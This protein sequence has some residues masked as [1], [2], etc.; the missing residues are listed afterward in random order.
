MRRASNGL[1]MLLAGAAC[2]TLAQ[3]ATA[4]STTP[5]AAP[6][7][8]ESAAPD[9]ASP[10]EQESPDIVVTATRKNESLQDVP[11]VVTPISNERIQELNLTQFSQ[12]QTL[13]PGLN[14]EPRGSA[15]TVTTLR[16]VSTTVTTGAPPAVVIYFNE[17]PINDV[18]AFQS[19]YDVG[20]IEVVRGPQGT[21]RGAPAP[22]GSITLT[23]RRPDLNEVGG[24]I[25]GTFTDRLLYNAQAAINLPIIQDKL[26]LRVAGLFDHNLNGDIFN[27]LTDARS[28]ARTVSGRATLLFAPTDALSI[29]A[30]Y[31]Y[32]DNRRDSLALVE[33]N[34]L[35]YNGPV[36]TD[37]TSNRQAVQDIADQTH[38]KAHLATV[39]A[40][41]DFGG[42]TLSYIGGFTKFHQLQQPGDQDVGNA[43]PG[44]SPNPRLDIPVRSW[45]HELRVDGSVR[46]FLDYTVGAFSSDASGTS[47]L[48]N[49]SP[50][51]G[52]FG[53]PGSAAPVLTTPDPRYVLTGDIRLPTHDLNR[54]VFASGT[55]HLP[56]RTDIVLGA[57]HIW[58]T[59]EKGFSLNF[60]PAFVGVAVPIP[61][62]LCPAVVPGSV[63]SPSYTGVCDIRVA[64]AAITEANPKRKFRTWVY[65]A[66]I[67]QHLNDDVLVYASYGHGWRGPGSNQ[68]SAIP[69]AAR[70]VNPEESNNYEI[71][72]KAELFDKKVRFNG[73]VF[74]QDFD[75]YIARARS[76]PNVN[77]GG[78]QVTAQDITF[79]GDARVRGFEGDLFVRP[80][81]RFYAQGTV[82]YANGK[83]KN[84]L[85]PCRDTNF[86]GIPDNGPTPTS[87]AAFPAGKPIAYCRSSAAI[88]D[89]PKWNFTVTSEYNV[90]L[91]GAEAYLR[92]IYTWQG[93]I[94]D[95][96]TNNNYDAYGTLNL[97][98][99]ARGIAKGLDINLFAKNILNV[100]R[101]R[102]RDAEWTF[103]GFRSGYSAV[104]YNAPREV[105]VTAR[106]SF[107]GG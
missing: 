73:A 1:S 32:L 62:F 22:A 60:N 70:N 21:L 89:A 42:A 64:P 5:G 97:F 95:L 91:G 36:I 103:G 11:L 44:Y 29:L 2:V 63:G 41:Y 16:G 77:E 3:A 25:D 105:G 69:I 65:D 88:S 101:L 39:S 86:D 12:I 48:V 17:V 45:S 78:F 9:V 74:Q 51:A 49:Y 96:S 55:V 72:L 18:I 98:L 81:S 14:I 27:P 99:G 93:K 26:A 40:K 6:A 53:R 79:N 33:G 68:A 30:T 46:N 59:A 8:G 85:V 20:Q 71:G 61:N 56:T 19:I 23:T 87:P 107:G 83:F 13:S 28:K 90:P 66:K 58:A 106:W 80:S 7:T 15:G 92:G 57:R 50:L 102:F 10:Q 52:A 35:G 82:G 24:T 37:A 84:A 100:E 75:G 76:I 38:L 4:Q 34:G 67:V 94:S 104:T 43:I 47:T 54:S 31:Q